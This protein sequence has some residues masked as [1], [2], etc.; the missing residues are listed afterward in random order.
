VFP[1]PEY[2]ERIEEPKT[3]IEWNYP[4]TR[5]SRASMWSKI[6][7]GSLVMG[8]QS[9]KRWHIN[10]WLP[11][12]QP[13]LFDLKGE[14]VPK[15]KTIYPGEYYLIAPAWFKVHGRVLHKYGLVNM[16]FD[17]K[18][19]AYRVMIGSDNYIPGY[20]LLSSEVIMPDMKWLSPDKN[21]LPYT[22]G[23]V[24]VFVKEL[25]L[26]EV[27]GFE[28]VDNNQIGMFYDTGNEIKRIRTFS[29]IEKFRDEI[30][31]NVPTTGKIWL[32]VIGRSRVFGGLQ[33]LK[34]LEF[35][36]IPS[37]KIKYDDR[38]YSF[39]EKPFIKVFKPPELN[40][41]FKNGEP[42]KN[43]KDSWVIKETATVARG[44]LSS[45]DFSF[46][47]KIP[48]SKARI[49]KQENKVLR[50][51]V[52]SDIEGQVITITGQKNKEARLHYLYGNN[53]IDLFFD[54]RGLARLEAEVLI[55]LANNEYSDINEVAI[56]IDG[57]TVCT[58]A[59]L[60]NIEKLINCMITCGTC[61]VSAKSAG[62]VEKLLEKFQKIISMPVNEVKIKSLP[63]IHPQL[64]AWFL[65][66][67]GCASVFDGTTVIAG[68]SKFDWQTM[69]ENE[70]L[71]DILGYVSGNYNE[72]ALTDPGVLPGVQRWKTILDEIKYKS[73]SL[74][75]IELIEEWAT[76][77]IE[78]EMP[79]RSRLSNFNGGKAMCMAWSSYMKGN[80]ER[81]LE[82]INNIKNVS[83]EI[84]A[85][86][87]VLSPIIYLRLARFN[88][89][90]EI[91]SEMVHEFSIKHLVV[92]GWIIYKIGLI[93]KPPDSANTQY[94]DVNLPLEENDAR[95]VNMVETLD[96]A[97]KKVTVK[98]NEDDW[99]LLYYLM[100]TDNKS[101][102]NNK[103][104]IKQRLRKVVGT[105]P[106][107]PEKRLIVEAIK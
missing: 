100:N 48:V 38:L 62:N 107:S 50:Y 21:K 51:F 85:L 77:I 70:K 92:I 7:S 106:A 39:N 68:D 88:A 4:A 41:T 66:I 33:T 57:R 13:V 63:N 30:K 1:S 23:P 16:P 14:L 54:H 9:Y 103:S 31:Q 22:E 86:K 20:S 99:L 59:I 96:L 78:G 69:V 36:V 40:F 74:Y 76:E 91:Y 37:C 84:S 6:Y 102:N 49:L 35:H 73:T 90:A 43:E 8:N 15:G 56:T 47:L 67:L 19:Y 34:T 24:D 71:K 5:L 42:A 65:N 83:K 26:L 81:A 3:G 97:R 28:A 87:C 27:S 82:L 95:L 89:A 12:D 29:D 98:N 64:N 75:S 44:V 79:Y 17:Y 46:D 32:S 11:D 25:P 72:A 60:I 61:K 101:L 52:E 2:V 53:F 80:Y 104:L 105:I 45:K 10:G 94:F 58:G 18:Y 93:A 55:E